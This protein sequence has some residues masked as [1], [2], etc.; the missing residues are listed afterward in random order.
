MIVSLE[1]LKDYTDLNV[2][3]EEFCEKMIMSGSNLETMEHVGADMEKVVV[4]KITKIEKHPDADRLSICQANIGSEVIQIVTA[5][6]NMKENDKVP[7]ALHKSTIADGTQITKGK[8]R[9]VLSNGMF[10]SEEE[11]GIAGDEP[12][13]GLMILPEDAPLGVEVKE[14]LGL[15]KS[16]LDFD[17]KIGRA[18]V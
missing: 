5:A 8:M 1:W 11:L 14:Y 9:G 3:P 12:V 7:V 15:N 17:I 10:C 6:T 2:S 18:H 4:G 13:H 16:I